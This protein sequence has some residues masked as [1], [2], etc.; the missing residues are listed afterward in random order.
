MTSWQCESGIHLWLSTLDLGL[1]TCFGVGTAHHTFLYHQERQTLRNLGKA[2]AETSMRSCKE[3]SAFHGS[4]RHLRALLFPASALA[5]YSHR[6]AW[7]RTFRLHR[8]CLAESSFKSQAFPSSL[9]EADLSSSSLLM[10][11]RIRRRSKPSKADPST[12]PGK[13]NP[14]NIPPVDEH[15]LR[16]FIKQKAKEPYTRFSINQLIAMVQFTLYLHAFLG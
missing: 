12:T 11:T 9:S 1:W 6:N 3:V 15:R 2:R 7:H 13:D 4:K 10:P 5:S 8:L 16:T 14:Y